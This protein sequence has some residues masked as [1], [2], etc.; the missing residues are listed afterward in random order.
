MCVWV[1]LTTDQVEATLHSKL[2]VFT[3]K[4]QAAN[5]RLLQDLTAKVTAVINPLQVTMGGGVDRGR[6][7]AGDARK[8]HDGDGGSL[9]ASA[10]KDIREQHAKLESKMDIFSTTASA[11]M[12]KNCEL[13]AQVANLRSQLESRRISSSAFSSLKK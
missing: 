2:D 1:G 11:L 10:L 6:V 9:G 7:V 3:S 4:V 12:M 13:Q 5:E 8:G